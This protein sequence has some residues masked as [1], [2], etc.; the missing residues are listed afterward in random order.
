METS[1][2]DCSGTFSLDSAEN[3]TMVFPESSL[4]KTQCTNSMSRLLWLG[5]I[6]LCACVSFCLPLNRAYLCKGYLCK[7]K[8]CCSKEHRRAVKQCI[9]FLAGINP[10]PWCFV[11]RV[12]SLWARNMM[13]SRDRVCH[14]KDFVQF[15]V[16][17]TRNAQKGVLYLSSY[18]EFLQSI[19]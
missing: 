5:F 4:E 12:P 3:I 1:D 14:Q 10:R 18:Y 19:L 6:A 13:E 8:C 7:W 11:Q 9:E 16:S 2:S 15:G 17:T